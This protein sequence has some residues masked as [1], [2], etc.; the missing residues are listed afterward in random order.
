MTDAI[1][2]SSGTLFITS[3]GNGGD[4]GI[5]DDNDIVGSY[6]CNIVS[7]N[8]LCVAASNQNGDL[9]SFSNYGSTTVHLAAPGTSILSTIMGGRYGSASGTSM[10]S[11]YVS[12][13]AALLWSYKPSASLSQ[14]RNALLSGVTSQPSLQGKVISGGR[15]NAYKALDSLAPIEPSRT[16]SEPEPQ[17]SPSPSPSPTPTPSPSPSP[18]PSPTPTPTPSPTQ[19]SGP[20]PVPS[21]PL[22]LPGDPSPTPTSSPSPTPTSSPSPEPEPTP[23]PETEHP[24][25]PSPQ[26]IEQD[27]PVVEL[28]VVKGGSRISVS[29]TVTPAQGGSIRVVLARK[30]AGVFK[31]VAVRN[32]RLALM[33]DGSGSYY[34]VR[35]ARPAAGSCRIRTVF[36]ADDGTRIV[37][38]KRFRC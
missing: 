38:G 11:P 18:S 26:P 1:T 37:T 6:P 29:G 14:V 9:A 28:R 8:L 23:E 2:R 3:A 33:G 21:L 16:D 31:R 17:P 35:F 20:L 4:D 19:S 30:R 25:V 12:G 13:V 32:P 10:A 22:P 7:T 36:L 5:G 24:E 15:L 27:P 34:S